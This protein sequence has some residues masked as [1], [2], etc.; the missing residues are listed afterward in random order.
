[1]VKLEYRKL[2]GMDVEFVSGRLE[3]NPRERAIGYTV[4]FKLKLDFTHF[5]QMASQYIPGY[6]NEPTNAIRPELGGLAYHHTYN[7]F[8]GAAGKID[9][10]EK[11][12]DIFA[13]PDFYMEDWIN[14][15]LERRYRKPEFA[16]VD[17]ALLITARQ[18]FRWEDPGRQIKIEDLPITTFHW[19]LSLIE[20]VGKVPESIYP[21]TKV[22][23]MYTHEDVVEVEGVPMLRGMRYI[24]GKKLKFGAI[25]DKQ[26]LTAS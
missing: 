8:F 18:D 4:V 3:E 2:E 24:D 13:R 5:V 11:L 14:G 15:A 1:M 17:G 10:S 26:V 6:L 21:V 16:I 19:A 23:L 25:T 9:S 12:F 22:V 7:Y 20:T